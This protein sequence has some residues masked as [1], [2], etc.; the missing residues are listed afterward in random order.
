MQLTGPQRSLLQGAPGFVGDAGHKIR[1][2]NT[3]TTDTA[4]GGHA[5]QVHPRSLVEETPETCPSRL[6]GKDEQSKSGKEEEQERALL[7]EA[8]ACYSPEAGE[9]GRCEQ[10]EGKSSQGGMRWVGG[11]GLQL[12]GPGGP[13]EGVRAPS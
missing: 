13:C 11:T 6:Q 9:H 4:R 10:L 3:E 2:E 8:A 7:V 5:W 12:V 1:R